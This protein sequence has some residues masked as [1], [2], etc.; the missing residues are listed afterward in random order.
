MS[1]ETRAE[2][3]EVRARP[4]KGARR[5]AWSFAVGTL[6]RDFVYTMVTVF[7]LVF[8]TEILDLDDATMWWVNGILLAARLFD[9]FTDIIMGG[10]VDNTRTRWGAY[11]PWIAVGIVLASV[12]AIMLFTDTGLRGG[13]FLAWFTV[14]YLMWGIAWTL[15]D[16]PYWSLLPALT[17]DPIEREKISSLTKVFATVGLFAAV[18]AVIPVTNA[19]GGTATAWTTFVFW[20][21]VVMIAFQAVT[22]IGVRQPAISRPQEK[23]SLRELAGIVLRNDQLVA[24]SVSMILF[25]T[26]YVTTTTFGVYFFKYAY[27]DENMYAPFAAVL[28]VAQLLGFALFPVARRWLS[29]KALFTSAIVMCVFG[30]TVFFFSPMNMIPI[31]LAGLLVFV[32]NAIIVVLIIVFITDCIEYGQWRTGR[33]NGAVTFALQPVINKVA[34]ALATA[35]AGASL[36]VTGINAA[37]TVDAVTEEGL[38]GMRIMMMVFPA[39]MIVLAYLVYLRW[40]RIDEAFHARIV[41]DLRERGELESV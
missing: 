22:L 40:Y 12:F 18:V 13:P 14:V 20:G 1:K 17:L 23:T 29:R 32:A 24:T 33:R 15:N 31:G 25:T 8:L 39:I 38:F 30:Y 27:R 3:P 37:P 28:G 11:K 4:P 41:A 6:G 10:I 36:I 34:G 7:L 19:L 26:G 21:V 2:T 5:N 16:I 35:S 9:A